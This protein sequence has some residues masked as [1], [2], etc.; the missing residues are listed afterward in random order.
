[1]ELTTF[2]FKN[3]DI[4]IVEIDGEPWFVAK[5]VAE[6]LGIGNSRQATS[7]LN[8]SEARHLTTANIIT[9]DV[10]FPN[11]GMTFISESGL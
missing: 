1:M 4:R 8:S 6:V 9:N 7:R 10:K 3:I 11:R 2:D 5:D